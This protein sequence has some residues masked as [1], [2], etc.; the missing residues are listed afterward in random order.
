MKSIF[1]GYSLFI[2]A[3]TITISSS[4]YL[5]NEGRAVLLFN[6]F[7]LKEREIFKPGIHIKI[8]L[9]EKTYFFSQK[10]R[11]VKIH[12][13]NCLLGFFWKP[14]NLSL[15]Q[16]RISQY[17]D[18]NRKFFELNLNKEFIQYQCDQDLEK[19]RNLF[20]NYLLT[21][22]LIIEKILF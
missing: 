21:Q 6:K 9:I 5:L 15:F 22:G 19:T 4:V 20:N 3:L 7:T 10:K 1:I 14:I 17:G 13:N 12:L 11:F 8:P 2:L 16:A 18:I